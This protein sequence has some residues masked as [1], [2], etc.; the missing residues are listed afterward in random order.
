MEIWDMWAPAPASLG[1]LYSSPLQLAEGMTASPK[2]NT[3]LLNTP[4][5]LTG[6]FQKLKTGSNFFYQVL[7]FLQNHFPLSSYI[8][9]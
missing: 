9:V 5:K 8:M 2:S 4:N 3:Q 6:T 7:N 1:K